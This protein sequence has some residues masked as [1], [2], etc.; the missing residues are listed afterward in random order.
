[1]E[2][3]FQMFQMVLKD[4][5]ISPLRTFLTGF[6][7]FIGIIAMITAVLVGTLG[8]ESLL[9]INAQIFGYSP[10]YAI[11]VVDS[12]L[13]DSEGVIKLIEIMQS[14]S[15]KTVVIYPNKEFSFAPLQNLSELNDASKLYKK[16]KN[17]EVVYTAAGYNEVY[18]VPITE[19]R[20]FMKTEKNKMEVVLNKKAYN[21]YQSKYLVAS[22][23]DTLNLTPFNVVGIVNDGKE[24]PIIYMDVKSVLSHVPS[25]FSINSLTIYWYNHSNLPIE[26]MRSYVDDALYDTIGGK[27]ENINRFDGG[28]NYISVIR[29]LQI[30]L[31]ITSSLLLFVAVL[32]QINIGLSSLEQRTQELLIRRALG[33]SK[34]NIAILVL[35]SLVFLSIIVCLISL[36]ISVG[37]VYM[38]SYLLP[39]DS[40]ITVPGYPV[41]AAFVAVI[42]SIGTALLGGLIPAIKAARLEPALALR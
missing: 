35:S 21:I 8:K 19:G 4:L 18:N 6:S 36:F 17:I 32:G 15:R 1:M 40:P 3:E 22:C 13:L 9:S 38:I 31:I 37:I 14:T 25:T 34:N 33:A 26:Q 12:N 7:M 29:M 41:I 10:T 16:I 20:W 23:K 24:Q 28:D 42:A 39:S 11:S 27:V 2:V 30:G 5:R